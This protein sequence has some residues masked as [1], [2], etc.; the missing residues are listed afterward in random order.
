ME[1]SL[2]KR[3]EGL[4]SELFCS[5]AVRSFL[6][7]PQIRQLGRSP[8]NGTVRWRPQT[9]G[10]SHSRL[11]ACLPNFLTNIDNRSVALNSSISESFFGSFPG[12]VRLPN[13]GVKRNGERTV[14]QGEE[15][16]LVGHGAVLPIPRIG[17]RLPYVWNTTPCS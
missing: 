3:T 16:R 14:G 6:N 10:Q 1:R 2:P 7:L 4:Q 9:T 11:P 13:V 17:R 5:V 12:T 8:S 15:H